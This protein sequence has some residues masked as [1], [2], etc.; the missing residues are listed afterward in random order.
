MVFYRPRWPPV[1]HNLVLSQINQIDVL[2][3]FDKDVQQIKYKYPAKIQIHA[4]MTGPSLL[5]KNVN[6]CLN[7]NFILTKYRKPSR[8]NVANKRT[9]SGFIG[10]GEPSTCKIIIYGAWEC[11]RGR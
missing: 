11:L 5:K 7:F 8:W 2:A 1:H 3:V 9:L 10:I 4:P 6:E